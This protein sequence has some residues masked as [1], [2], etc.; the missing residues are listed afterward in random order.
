MSEG[1]RSC[2]TQRAQASEIFAV[3]E[4]AKERRNQAIELSNF[5]PNRSTFLPTEVEKYIAAQYQAFY[6]SSICGGDAW[7]H[8]L[9]FLDVVSADLRHGRLAA[10]NEGG[11]RQFDTYGWWR[12]ESTSSNSGAMVL[13]SEP[14]LIP[15]H[16]PEIASSS[17]NLALKTPR[18]NN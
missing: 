7:R 1:A 4:K 14:I 12:K 5:L 2:R 10:A 11:P 9:Q 17:S 3:L 18:L 6:S 15:H 8:Q 16:I 13:P